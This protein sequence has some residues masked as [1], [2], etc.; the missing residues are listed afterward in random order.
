MH[1]KEKTLIFRGLFL[2]FE[3]GSGLISLIRYRVAH[4]LNP[5]NAA[6]AATGLIYYLPYKSKLLT[7]INK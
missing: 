1:K 4:P 5:L 7:V 2:V 3:V 6:Y